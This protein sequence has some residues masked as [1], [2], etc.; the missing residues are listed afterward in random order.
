MPN[1]S[2]MIS[3]INVADD[4]RLGGNIDFSTPIRKV[5]LNF[6][7]KFRENWNRGINQ[8]NGEQNIN[9]NFSH[10]LTLSFDNRKKEKWDVSVGGT[11]QISDAKYSIQS[12]LNKTYYNLLAQV[13]INNLH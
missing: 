13:D 11:F 9:T 5:G 6:N 10:S 8:V 4:Y 3:L 1:L 7:T 12:S 2:Q